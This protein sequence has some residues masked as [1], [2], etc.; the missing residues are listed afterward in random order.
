MVITA[1]TTIEEAVKN[2]VMAELDGGTTANIAGEQA[3]MRVFLLTQ[4]IKRDTI[5]VV[6]T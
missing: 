2:A 5:L 4:A 3:E 1:E 6:K